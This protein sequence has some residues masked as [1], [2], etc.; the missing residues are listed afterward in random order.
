M[1]K[2]IRL[3]ITTEAPTIQIITTAMGSLLIG[4]LDHFRIGVSVV[5]VNRAT[6][7][8]MRDMAPSW[9]VF[10]SEASP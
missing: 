7:F 3:N 8:G 1:G 5:S 10:P 9:K 6:R 2:P 4:S